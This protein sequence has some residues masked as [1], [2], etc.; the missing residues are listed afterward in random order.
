MDY[1]EILFTVEN[2]IAFL[3]LNRPDIRNAV[4]GAKMIEEIETA[5]GRI[6]QD[7]DV[8]VMVLSAVDPVFSAG[9]N[10]KDMAGKKGMFAGCP[11]EVMENY[12]RNI[13]RIPLAVYGLEIPS[14]A[15]V[16]G[17]ALGAGCDLALMCDM[18]I[19]S[20]KAQFGETFI[21]LG[22]V[23][24][25]GG[26]YFL[27]RIVGMAAACEL[28][29]TGDIIDAQRALKIGMVNDVVAHERLMGQT[30][31]LAEK[32][33]SKPAAAIRMTKRLLHMGQRTG[34][35]EI[36]EQSAAYQAICHT[37]KEHRQALSA[38]LK[39]MK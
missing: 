35:K 20:E 29:F 34:L 10:I 7:M 36:L 25:D 23:S 3:T 15:A 5:C 30:R 9:G 19:A 37:T 33:A 16:N 6:N 28:S 1:K 27:P 26:A 38:M 39:K 31:V 18:R 17:P 2:G 4:S 21:N 11:S 32:I 12:R 22:I 14:I 24:G 8:K 13:Q